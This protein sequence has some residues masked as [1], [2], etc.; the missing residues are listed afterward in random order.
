MAGAQAGRH[1]DRTAWMNSHAA[2]T[3]R[4][5]ALTRLLDD[6]FLRSHPDSAMVLADEGVALAMRSGDRAF[7][8]D[9][10]WLRARVLAEHDDHA[11]AMTQVL[12]CLELREALRDTSGV[13]QAIAE[14]GRLAVLRGA[15]D[16][17]RPVMERGL[18]LARIVHDPGHEGAILSHQ[19]SMY[20]QLGDFPSAMRCMGAAIDIERRNGASAGLAGNLITLGTMYASQNDLENAMAFYN[21]GLAMCDAVG[22]KRFKANAL[23]NIASAHFRKGEF[24]RGEQ[25]L[26]KAMGILDELGDTFTLAQL[27]MN[28]AGVRHMK[29]DDPRALKLMDGYIDKLR[30][31]G[32]DSTEHMAIARINMAVVCL[33]IG[34]YPMGAEQARAG[35]G[36]AQHL[37]S[38]SLTRS[39]AEHLTE[40]YKRMGRPA[41]AL[42]MY[43][44]AVAAR[45]SLASARNLKAL[46]QQ[47]FKYDYDKKEFLL[48]A[49]QEKKVPSLPRNSVASGCSAT[50]SSPASGSCCCSRPPSSCSA[51]A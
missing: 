48:M 29:G 24:D 21:E 30:G 2:D 17:A 14:L 31:M 45:D 47:K 25:V 36:I 22:E 50:P 8:A 6:E 51:T 18:E 20:Q 35:L 42:A 46:M 1:A 16:E 49:E 28:M 11:L 7:I 10:R 26:M 3:A 34:R 19:A 33:R 4:L 44:L 37:G 32:L 38:L 9:A 43:E 12:S 23:A 40:L 41:D 13:L 5:S 39:A 15:F 27:T